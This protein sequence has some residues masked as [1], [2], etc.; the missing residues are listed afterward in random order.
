M[1]TCARSC[2]TIRFVDQLV[3]SG[4]RAGYNDFYPLGSKNNAIFREELGK[5][6]SEK[7]MPI[8]FFRVRAFSTI[9]QIIRSVP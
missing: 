5:Q 1:T 2:D 9:C 7:L 3:A 6:K 8:A 4:M